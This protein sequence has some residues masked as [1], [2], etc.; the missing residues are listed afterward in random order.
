MPYLLR[1][2]PAVPL[3]CLTCW[4]H[5]QL[6]AVF[7]P[8]PSAST[9]P[10]S[11]PASLRRVPFYSR[12]QNGVMKKIIVWS[13]GDNNLDVK[14]KSRC[15][16]FGSAQS[17]LFCFPATQSSTSTR[18]CH[19]LDLCLLSSVR[20]SYVS[21]FFSPVWR[22]KAEDTLRRY[23]EDTQHWVVIYF[24]CRTSINKCKSEWLQDAL[25]VHLRWEEEEV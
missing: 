23:A 16:P 10:T 13:W 25:W 1:P 17:V 24:R 4:L 11:F 20:A 14:K 12:P 18:R 21:I 8:F 19:Q 15:F 22:L 3:T 9:F 6:S 7:S 5:F 2:A